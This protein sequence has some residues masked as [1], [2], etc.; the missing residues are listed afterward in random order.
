[1]NQHTQ[2]GIF[3]LAQTPSGEIIKGKGEILRS[4]EMTLLIKTVILVLLTN[5]I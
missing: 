4:A 2:S 3:D 1:M 5:F